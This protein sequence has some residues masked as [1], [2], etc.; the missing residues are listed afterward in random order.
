MVS[1]EVKE[2]HEAGGEVSREELCSH[3]NLSA[4]VLPASAEFKGYL[5]FD[6]LADYELGLVL[7]AVSLAD[8]PLEGCPR[9]AHKL[10]LG[11]PIG[12]GSVRVDIDRIALWDPV[13]GWRAAE[14]PGEQDIDAAEAARLVKAF[15]TWLVTG[16]E[17][18]DDDTM[19]AEFD[20]QEFYRD[21]CEVLTLD[22][23]GDGPVQYHP[24]EV[25]P[26]EGYRYFTKQR[27]KRHRGE[28][29]PLQTPRDLRNGKRQT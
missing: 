6:S 1:K 21:L 8:S 13:G 26:Y 16:E 14:D 17:T 5:E 9:R 29:Q 28:E 11:R 2:K 15:K 20:R 19:V 3:Q 22:L 18:P 4:A 10:G 12:L 27:Q 25:P 24:P 23:A 7:W